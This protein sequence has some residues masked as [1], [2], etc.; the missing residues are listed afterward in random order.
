VDKFYPS[1]FLYKFVNITYH[2]ILEMKYPAIYLTTFCLLTSLTAVSQ[3]SQLQ[4][5]RNA[6]GKLQV[7]ISSGGDKAKQ[8]AILSE[9]LKASESA[10]S[11]KKTKKWSETW[12]I[13][14]YLS[15]YI[16]LLDDNQG[17]ADKYLSSAIAA[18]DSA[19]R[20]DKYQDNSGLIQA[21]I[22]NINAKKLD[23]GNLAF[24]NKDFAKAFNKLKEVSDYLPKDTA[25]AINTALSAVSLQDY[26]NAIVYFERAKN[27]G[28]K[29]PIAFQHLA[30]I[31]ISKFDYDAAIK[32]LEEGLKINAGY[33]YL[34]FDY[35]NLLL[36]TE[37]YEKAKAVIENTIKIDDKNKLL[38]Y[39]YGY[40]EQKSGNSERAEL[41]YKKALELDENYFEALYQ[42]GLTYI[43]SANKQL[44]KSGN[45]QQLFATF[46]D[47]S[48]YVLNQAYEVNPND[49]S[50]IQLLIDINMRKNRLDKAQD[51]RSKLQEF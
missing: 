26:P 17:N 11:D 8:L 10:R 13:N 24:N 36:D 5:A 9:G 41:A 31:Y 42:L 47:K 34:T 20:L 14:A 40:L 16:S 30:T 43:S 28:I 23:Q 51:L 39:L 35:I 45:S 21:S 48:E 33:T 3:I 4:I 22:Y 1:L 44:S 7:S 2:H 37:K 12:A 32:V 27:N 49:R 38:Y 15:S 19:M 29:N 18:V 50:T 25:I 46:L 6:V